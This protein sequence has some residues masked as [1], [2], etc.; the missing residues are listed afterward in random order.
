MHSVC[1]IATQPAGSAIFGH[2]TCALS[3]QAC[4]YRSDE[5]DI[6]V[7]IGKG[8][9]WKARVSDCSGTKHLVYALLNI[10]DCDAVAQT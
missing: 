8:V 2:Q 4:V 6:W 1:I 5:V 3:K 9:G 10:W 7:H